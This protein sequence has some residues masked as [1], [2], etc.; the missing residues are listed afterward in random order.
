VNRKFNKTLDLNDTGSQYV[1]ID[2]TASGEGP[3]EGIFRQRYRVPMSFTC[4]ACMY[5][6]MHIKVSVIAFRTKYGH[7]EMM[8]TTE[9]RN[10]KAFI[11]IKNW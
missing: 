4:K 8:T 3:T 11:I 1:N 7:H 6:I 10:K 5:I 9:H 2:K